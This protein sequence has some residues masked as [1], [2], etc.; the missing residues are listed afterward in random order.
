MHHPHLHLWPKRRLTQLHSVCL[1]LEIGLIPH[2][3]ASSERA[4]SHV[5]SVQAAS[6]NHGAERMMAARCCLMISSY[7]ESCMVGMYEIA[8]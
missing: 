1:Q 7:E 4:L 3:K 5:T 6:R 8:W 2:L